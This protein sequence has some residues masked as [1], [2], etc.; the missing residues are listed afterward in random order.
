V[1]VVNRETDLWPEG[2]LESALAP[3]LRVTQTQDLAYFSIYTFA[4]R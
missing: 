2:W 1:I 3:T 4:R